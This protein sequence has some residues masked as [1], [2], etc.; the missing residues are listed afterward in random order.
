MN[1]VEF[2]EG[3]TFV[4]LD[5][6]YTEPEENLM[7]ICSILFPW[8]FLSPAQRV[9][10][11]LNLHAYH[12]YMLTKKDDSFLPGSYPPF[13]PFIPLFGSTYIYQRPFF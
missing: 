6:N 4:G 13:F 2:S 9:F 11:P 3:K 7:N 12:N 10:F 8:P 1:D 5:C